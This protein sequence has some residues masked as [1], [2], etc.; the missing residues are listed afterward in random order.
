MWEVHASLPCHCIACHTEAL[1]ANAVDTSTSQCCCS[2]SH[3]ALTSYGH[4]LVS[5]SK[6]ALP[7]IHQKF[8]QPYMRGSSGRCFTDAACVRHQAVGLQMQNARQPEMHNNNNIYACQLMISLGACMHLAIA[9]MVMPMHLLLVKIWFSLLHYLQRLA[10]IM[11]V[12]NYHI[13]FD[14]A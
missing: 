6:L 13:Q 12:A 4:V 10:C 5:Y 11:G 2:C 8:V 1:V 7:F 9:Q 3:A 14:I